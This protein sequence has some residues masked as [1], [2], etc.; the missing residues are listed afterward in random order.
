MPMPPR[1]CRA[2]RATVRAKCTL[3]RLAMLI[4]A[5]VARF[6]FFS[7]P[8]RQV[9]S[10]ALVISV[11]ISASFFCVSW[12]CPIGLPNWMRSLL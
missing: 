1:I 11:I 3:L 4:C 9:S 10:W 2:S 6:S 5:V 12:N 8:K 7:T